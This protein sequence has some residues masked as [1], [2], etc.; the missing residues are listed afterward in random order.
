[1]TVHPES[2]DVG[3]TNMLEL[4]HG[5]IS[6]NENNNEVRLLATAANTDNSLFSNFSVFIL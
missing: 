5:N 6:Y 4:Y 1:M 3:G 2:K